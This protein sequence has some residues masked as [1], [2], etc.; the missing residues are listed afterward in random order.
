MRS[1]CG[2]TFISADR[3]ERKED[4]K[5]AELLQSAAAPFFAPESEKG[6]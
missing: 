4:L 2:M 3:L 5:H 6:L 1:A